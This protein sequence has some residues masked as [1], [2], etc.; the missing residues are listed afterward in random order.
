ML[1][2]CNPALMCFDLYIYIDSI[3]SCYVSRPF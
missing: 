1:A 3:V 2:E